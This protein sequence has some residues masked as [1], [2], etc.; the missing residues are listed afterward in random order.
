MRTSSRSAGSPTASRAVH[1]VC[2]APNARAGMKAPFARV[3]AVLPGR[4]YASSGRKLRGVASEGMLCSARELGLSEDAAGLMELPPRPR[5]R[6]YGATW[7]WT[8]RS[9]RWT[10]P[11]T[12]A[13]AWAWRASPGRWGCCS[14]R[15]RSIRPGGPVASRDHRDDACR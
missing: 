11:P 8:T 3:G 7:P 9:L 5:G 2:G 4:T 10:S 14:A 12:A 15:P 13:T 6:T 1:V